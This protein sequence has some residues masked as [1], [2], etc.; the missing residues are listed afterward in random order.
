MPAESDPAWKAVPKGKPCFIIWRIEKLKVVP[1]PKDHYGSFYSG[2]SYIVLNDRYQN[3]WNQ[4]QDMKGAL[5]MH[6]HFWLGKESSQ[7]EE[8]VAAFK[9]VEL[10]DYLGGAPVQHRETQGSESTRFMNYFKAK[11]GIKYMKGGVASGFNHVEQK[12]TQRLLQVKGRHHVRCEEVDKSW[13]S[14]NDGDVF[15]LDLGKVQYVWMGKESSRTERIK[16]MEIARSLR[17]ERGGGDIIAVDSGEEDSM[18][19]SEKKLW[20]DHLRISERKVKAS[21]EGGSDEK[22]ERI[23]S[24]E[25]KLFLVSDEGGTLKIEEVKTGPLHKSDLD[26]KDSFIVDNGEA[27][28][29]VWNGKQAS[30][31]ERSEAM[32]NAVGFC[33]KKG[34]ANKTSVTKVAD[35][36]EPTEFK[37][38]FK[39]WPMPQASGK[40]YVAGGKI[41]KTVQTKFDASALHSN[42]PLAAQTQMV[43]DGS[44]TTQVWRIVDFDMVPVERNMI[45]QFFG[46]DCYIILYTYQVRNK[47]NSI[48][49]YWQGSKSSQDEKGASAMHAVQ[50][51]DKMGGSPVQ[52]RVVQGKEPPHFMAIFGGKMII[53]SGGKAGWNQSQHSNDEGPGEKYMLQVRGTSALNSKAIQVPCRAASLNSNDVF[54]LF[55]KSSVSIWS[56]KGSTGDEREMAKLIAKHSPRE[57]QMIFEG[58]EKPEFWAALGGK[59]EYASDK[60]LQEDDSDHP[61]RLFQCSNASGNFD[62]EEIPDFGQVDLCTDDVMLLDAWDQ[63]FIWIGEGANKTEKENAERVAIEYMRTDPSGRDTDTAIIRIKQGFEPPNFTGYFG[64]WDRD[65]YQTKAEWRGKT[66]EE[67]KKELGEANMGV[68]KIDLNGNEGQEISFSKVAKYPYEQLIKSPDELPEG[69]DATQREVYLSAEDFQNLFECSYEEFMSKPVWKQQQMKRAKQ[70]F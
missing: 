48:I 70:L 39:T 42:Q 29:W 13:N 55:T 69:V 46:G 14:F 54:V 30:K 22:V 28:V 31:Q 67:L 20:N 64:F 23:K 37:N 26:S 53:Y 27:G 44:G 18:H 43:D 50:L 19:P 11:G 63:I 65:I 17:D 5:D 51:D 1:V 16:G 21:R 45:G 40:A 34:Y 41:A 66:Y 62:V 59:E 25:I 8:G 4:V 56:G 35:G 68:A 49:Y 52:V 9:T 61:V 15:I 60:R 32:R 2:D 33:K 24:S 7:D 36:G 57:P 10:D 6:I 3:C 12:V 58:Q 38:L 47:D